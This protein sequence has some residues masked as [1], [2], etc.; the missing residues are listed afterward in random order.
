[1]R[2]EWEA[3][4]RKLNPGTRVMEVDGSEMEENEKL[5]SNLPPIHGFPT[6]IL[7]KKG[8]PVDEFK[9][10][11]T[12]EEMKKFTE[13]GLNTNKRS[14]KRPRMTKRKKARRKTMKKR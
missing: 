13:N 12:S 2:P 3:M 1:M 11:R 9:G 7:M 14:V 5:K 6:F 4:K 10:E 8:R